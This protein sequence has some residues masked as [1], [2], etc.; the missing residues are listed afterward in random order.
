MAEEMVDNI[1]EFPPNIELYSAMPYG[2]DGGGKEDDWFHVARN[3]P[4]DHIEAIWDLE[5]VFRPDIPEEYKPVKLMGLESV[6]DNI[7]FH[8]AMNYTSWKYHEDILIWA[9][10]ALKPGGQLSIIAPDIDWILKLWLAEAIGQDPNKY[11]QNTQSAELSELNEII[12]NS[13]IS[14]Q[15]TEGQGKRGGWNPI[16]SM[17]N[18]A[19]IPPEQFEP[20]T[21]EQMVEAVPDKIHID[22]RNDFDFDLW[23]MQQLYS[24]GSGDPQDSFKSVFNRR[25]LATLLRRTQF[26]IR[27]LQNNPENPAQIEAK[28]FKHPSRLLSVGEVTE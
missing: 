26:V 6:F 27:L 28:A 15:S 4:G 8:Y 21:R 19:D 13:Q 16:R 1:S 24:S 5:L 22:V 18:D 2:G 23:L 7:R 14:V 9:L 25:Y 11:I 17:L 20:P 12:Q 10:R 3:T